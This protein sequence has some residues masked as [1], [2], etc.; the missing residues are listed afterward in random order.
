MPLFT[1]DRARISARH[2]VV[3]APLYTVHALTMADGSRLQQYVGGNGQVFAVRWNTLYK[4]NLARLL[5]PSFAN[6]ADAAQQA[7]QQGGIQR[8][9][10]HQGRVLGLPAHG[11]HGTTSAGMR[12]ACV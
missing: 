2:A 4:P 5:G 9:F 6:Y 1:A 8:Q 11:P 10:H 12:Y 3:R 7:A